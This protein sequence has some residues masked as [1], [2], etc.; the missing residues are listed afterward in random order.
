MEVTYGEAV[1]TSGAGSLTTVP[2]PS[3][4]HDGAFR[5]PAFSGGKPQVKVG[6]GSNPKCV[7]LGA[8]R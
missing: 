6:A 4:C 1:R 3:A 2:F 8:V 7:L 5:G